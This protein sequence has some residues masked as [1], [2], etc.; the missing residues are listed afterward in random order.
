MREKCWSGAKV[1]CQIVI[2]GFEQEIPT[3]KIREKKTE[4]PESLLR[5]DASTS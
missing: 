3:G 4:V 2:K 1:L 5:A